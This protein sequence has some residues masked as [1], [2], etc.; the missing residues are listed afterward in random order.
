M[1]KFCLLALCSLFL[2]TGCGEKKKE[3]AWYLNFEATPFKWEQSSTGLAIAVADITNTSPKKCNSI[4]IDLIYKR[5]GTEIHKTCLE[6][7]KFDNGE[8]FTA[9]CMYIGDYEDIITKFK[10]KIVNIKCRD[11][12]L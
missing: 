3:K 10:I 12:E 7:P 9:K 2:F 6:W 1:K 8:T 11:D 4:A 5:N